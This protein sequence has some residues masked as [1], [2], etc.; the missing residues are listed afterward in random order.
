MYR[1][2]LRTRQ[3]KHALFCSKL[4][5]ALVTQHVLAVA[6]YFATLVV[7]L[8]F[9]FIIW[10]PAVL[11]SE[12]VLGGAEYYVRS[13]RLADLA[14]AE[15]LATEAYVF[16]VIVLFTDTRSTHAACPGGF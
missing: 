9:L 6:V 10:T 4:L 15:F 5:R 2:V 16:C 11:L 14:G 8:R 7:G 1:L 12:H 13:T 3:Q